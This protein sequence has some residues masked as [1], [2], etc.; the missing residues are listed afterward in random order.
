MQVTFF[1]FFSIFLFLFVFFRYIKEPLILLKKSFELCVIST[2]FLDIGHVAI[3]GDFIIEYNYLFTMLFLVAAII[4]LIF[5]H[6]KFSRNC[7]YFLFFVLSIIFSYFYHIIFKSVY[8]S[9]NFATTWDVFFEGNGELMEISINIDVLQT[10][11]RTLI[12]GFSICVLT[13]SK[14]ITSENICALS[15]KIVFLANFYL[16]YLLFEF[17]LLNLF[18]SNILRDFSYNF[19]GFS[20]SSFIGSR[21]VLGFS[22]PMGI[23]REPS[24][25]ALCCFYILIANLYLIFVTRKHLFTFIVYSIFCLL[26]GSLS[27]YWYAFII[28]LI[29]F[30]ALILKRKT[31][32][33]RIFSAKT[34]FFIIFILIFFV[35]AIFVLF[36]NRIENILSAIQNFDPYNVKWLEASSEIIRIYSIYNNLY[37]FARNFLLGTGLGTIYSFSATITLITNVGIIGLGLFLGFYIISLNNNMIYKRKCVK[38]ILVVVLLM[39]FLTTGHL[40]YIL[41]FEKTFFIMF[42]IKEIFFLQADYSKKEGICL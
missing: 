37:Y 39:M 20:E 27:S 25:L 34:I 36:G 15:K 17:L 8:Y 3:V 21:V 22:M 26:I 38:H 16:L 4:Y 41:Y 30:V 32:T 13:Q 23:A 28:I 19:F 10:L 31:L 40:G 7:I 11:L 12:F 24:N 1:G 2:I 6:P 42:L 29:I 9:S 18:N 33:G 5:N 14:L 35:F